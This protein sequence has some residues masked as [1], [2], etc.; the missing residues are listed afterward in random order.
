MLRGNKKLLK[1][2]IK[3]LYDITVSTFVGTLSRK[4]KVD[5]TNNYLAGVIAS[6]HYLI[7][8]DLPSEIFNKDKVIKEFFI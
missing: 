3:Y 1:L 6:L 8:T 7:R 2:P 5:E 4:I